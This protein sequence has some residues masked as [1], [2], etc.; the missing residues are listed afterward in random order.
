MTLRLDNNSYNFTGLTPDTSYHLYVLT[1][2]IAGGDTVNALNTTFRTA[3]V[4]EAVPGGTYILM[5][6]I[7][8]C[9]IYTKYNEVSVLHKSMY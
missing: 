6:I 8:F 1:A 3:T 2:N 7:N 5:Y 9:V 4:A